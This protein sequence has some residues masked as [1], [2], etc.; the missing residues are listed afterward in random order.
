MSQISN[1][2]NVSSD[3]SSAR[4]DTFSQAST[5]FQEKLEETGNTTIISTIDN[6]VLTNTEMLEL[7]E[8]LKNTG[9][10]L[11]EFVESP[12]F[13]R[14]YDVMR[15][16]NA[17]QDAQHSKQTS[18]KLEEI[19]IENEANPSLELDDIEDDDDE[20]DDSYAARFCNCIRRL[21]IYLSAKPETRASHG[22]LFRFLVIRNKVTNLTCTFAVKSK[23]LWDSNEIERSIRPNEFWFWW[24]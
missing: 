18:D 15:N 6:D 16:I 23:S 5:N 7:D 20:S 9:R 19:A 4:K 3:T 1:I 11:E 17:P 8:N 12:M 21:R 24:M 10:S 13:M 2:S 14:L 22:G